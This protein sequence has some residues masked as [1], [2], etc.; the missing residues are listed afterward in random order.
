MSQQNQ[1]KGII[2][3]ILSLI[4]MHTLAA[5]IISLLSYLLQIIYGGYTLLGVWITGFGGF[6]IWQ[7]LYVIPICIL[8]KRKRKHLI[9][10]GVIIGA[11]ITALVNGGCYLLMTSQ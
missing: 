6:F 2:Q 4:L 1:F 5:S 9:M 11:V 7:L 10:K 3:G 8:L